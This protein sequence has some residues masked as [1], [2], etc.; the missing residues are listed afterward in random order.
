LAQM[1]NSR[2]DSDYAVGGAR[3]ARCRA[4]ESSGATWSRSDE[5]RVIGPGVVTISKEA[6]ASAGICSVWQT[7]QA[8][9]GPP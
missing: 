5:Y 3:E 7:W 2:R 4:K 9:S 6:A 8:V 1:D